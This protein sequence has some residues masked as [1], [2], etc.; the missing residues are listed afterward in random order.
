MRL[1]SGRMTTDFVSVRR[2]RDTTEDQESERL[3]KPPPSAR[4]LIPNKDFWPSG[5]RRHRASAV[6]GKQAMRCAG[7]G[8]LLLSM[9]CVT[10]LTGP[11]TAM[12]SGEGWLG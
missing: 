6:A 12:P 5:M 4:P 9:Q 11:P 10:L 7:H 3:G 2:V 1:G 8:C